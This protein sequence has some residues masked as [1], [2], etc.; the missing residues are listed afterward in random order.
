MGLAIRPGKR[1]KVTIPE[2]VNFCA[3]QATLTEKAKP[4]RSLLRVLRTGTGGTGGTG[5]TRDAHKTP[6]NDRWMILSRLTTD[7]TESQ[8]LGGVMF[9][10][11]QRPTQC[12]QCAA[13]SSR[14]GA[15]YP[16]TPVS[17][18]TIQYTI[19]FVLPNYIWG[20]CSI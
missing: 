5:G 10:C 13:A 12:T 14:H 15:A 1:T 9:W 3:N 2:H 8:F 17:L 20:D 6:P 19:T 4:G 18:T 16:P 7:Q 11:E